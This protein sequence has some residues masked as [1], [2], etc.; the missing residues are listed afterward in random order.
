MIWQDALKLLEDGKN[1]LR[2]D[3]GYPKSMYISLEEHNGAMHFYKRGHLP[4]ATQFEGHCLSYC[5]LKSQLWE[6]SS[7]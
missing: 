4:N 2:T 6:V 7:I 3:W 5:D 1:L